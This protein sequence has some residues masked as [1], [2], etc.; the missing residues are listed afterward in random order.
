MRIRAPKSTTFILFCCLA[1]TLNAAAQVALVKPVKELPADGSLLPSAFSGWQKAAD[2]R[3]G[4]DAAQ[5]DPAHAAL[6][7]E[8][9]LVGFEHASYTRQGRR[10]DVK[11]FRFHDATG[12]FAAYSALQAGPLAAERFC[13]H[14]GSSGKRALMAC[15][16]L[17][18]DVTY[19]KVTPMTPAELRALAAQLPLATGPAALAPSALAY[20]PK[21]GIAEVRFALGPAGL[22]HTGT[23]LP[24]EVIDFGKSAEVV[25]GDLAGDDGGDSAA[26]LTIVRYPTFALA[27]ERQQ[28]FEAWAKARP[29]PATPA[30]PAAAA[31]APQPIFFTRRIG[32]LVAVV[33]G[34][35]GLPE[36]RAFAERIPY[37]VEITQNEPVYNPKDNIGNLVVNMLYLSFIIIG[38]TFVTGLALGGVRILSRKFFPGRFFDRPENVEFIK[39]DLRD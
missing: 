2:S 34:N 36:A 6:F 8:T 38:F 21:E 23:P 3:R 19:E 37:D 11:A 17:V 9:G 28:A 4:A 7:K 10:L 13:E 25:V 15:T 33:S 27:T 18:V 12:A 22:K 26:L 24:P 14:A 31:P 20:M 1:L 32:P 35:I 16:N 39:L 5:A 30:Q 29:V